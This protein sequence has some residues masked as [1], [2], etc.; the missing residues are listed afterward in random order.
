MAESL[1]RYRIVEEVGQGGMSVVYRAKDTSLD[2]EVA[3]KILHQHLAG[4]PEARARFHR[5]ARAVAKLRHPNIL[6]IYDYSGERS[7]QSFIVTEFI[8][9]RTLRTFAGAR[10]LPLPELAAMVCIKICEALA[11]AHDQGILHRDLKP[12][13]IMVRDDGTLKLMDF[14][15]AQMV[16]AQSVTMTGTL[17]GSPAHM[18]PEH[19]EGKPLDFRADVFALGTILYYLATGALPFQGDNPHAVFRQIMD[20]RYREPAA[21]NP[22]VGDELARI[23]KK[24][25]AR[26]LAARTPTAAAMRDQLLALVRA[27]GIDDVDKE[28]A[29]YFR[30]PDKTVAL[31]RPRV[32]AALVKAGRW[33]LRDG[34]V[35]EAVDAFN[36]VLALDETN[37]EVRTELARIA[38]SKR[39]RAL[40]RWGAAAAG[41]VALSSFGVYKWVTRP[42]D[43]VGVPWTPSGTASL[44]GVGVGT[45]IPTAAPDTAETIESAVPTASVVSV[46]STAI[47][48]APRLTG[49]SVAASAAPKGE[50]LA[51]EVLTSPVEAMA[52]T[53]TLYLD[54]KPYKTFEPVTVLPKKFGY[55]GTIEIESGRT[56]K[57][58]LRGKP[59]K[60]YGP[61]EISAPRDDRVGAD[62]TWADATLT[63]VADCTDA[64]I[65]GLG[66]RPCNAPIIVPMKKRVDIVTG[67]T[68]IGGVPVDIEAKVEAGEI[69]SWRHGS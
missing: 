35:G 60:N 56:Y 2:R 15:I 17:L 38:R 18:S 64:A 62:F 3:L 30:D 25:M 16:D 6:E 4:Q 33:S 50:M 13:N 43:P 14:G 36:R 37:R 41:A 7:D 66:L 27:S 68:T 32:V 1:E 46:A 51:V 65:E 44:E 67:N 54:G 20:G 49:A 10:P 45:A 12:E 31:L 57:V 26:D 19:I 59:F 11:H 42:P 29:A 22:A 8:R 55:R 40:T 21:L 28:V 23:I 34:K 48:S 5:E 58:E 69:R 63:V 24:A 52:E 39:L 53:I 9:G 47:A 61:T